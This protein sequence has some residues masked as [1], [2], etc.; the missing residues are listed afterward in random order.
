[1]FLIN[2]T[3]PICKK[4]ILFDDVIKF[5][6]E[7]RD[8]MLYSSHKMNTYS[9]IRKER[10]KNLFFWNCFLPIMLF[11]LTQILEAFQIHQAQANT[12]LQH[13]PPVEPK[14]SDITN[15]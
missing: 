8:E 9:V 6:P 14:Q 3:E 13:P 2:K 5:L 10:V 1:M 7:A 11:Y 12:F 15:T 4:S